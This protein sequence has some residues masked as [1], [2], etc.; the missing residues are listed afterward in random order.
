MGNCGKVW[1]A[2]GGARRQGLRAPPVLEQVVDDEI[3]AVLV[4]EEDVKAPVHEP[5]P[6]LQLLQHRHKGIAVNGVLQLVQL[7]QSTLPVL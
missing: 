5:G 4:V 2:A 3:A 1:R 7:L 6:L